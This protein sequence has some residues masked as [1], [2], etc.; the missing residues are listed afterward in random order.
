[1]WARVLCSY[2]SSTASELKTNSKSVTLT[3]SGKQ[4]FPW[5][6]AENWVDSL[7]YMWFWTCTYL[8]CLQSNF[9]VVSKVTI[10]FC[11]SDMCNRLYEVC[12]QCLTGLVIWLHT[13]FCHCQQLRNYILKVIHCN[14]SSMSKN[15]GLEQALQASS[16]FSAEQC[17]EMWNHQ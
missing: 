9:S 7:K 15:G 4:C 5:T 11:Q 10:L 16:L 13:V 17:T 2:L 8:V 14:P 1:M 3:D 12:S 6:T